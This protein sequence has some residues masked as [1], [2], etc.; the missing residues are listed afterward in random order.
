MSTSVST[1]GGLSQG[2]GD[3]IWRTLSRTLSSQSNLERD[4]RSRDSYDDLDYVERP[5]ASK[6]E[7]WA[8]MPEIKER[9]DHDEKDQFKNRKLGVT[10]TDLTVTGISADAAIAEDVISQ[11]NKPRLIAESRHAPLEK[12]ILDN[13]HGCVRPGEMLLVL[14][15]PGSGCSS[16]LKILANRR[17]GYAGVKGDV[18]FGSMNHKQAQQYRGQI[19]MNTEDEL[20]FP[21][22]TVGQT[23]DFATRMKIPMHRPSDSASAKDY[24][25]KSKDFLLRSLGISHTH[26]TKVGNEYVR[27]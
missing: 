12:T 27:G 4:P 3:V 9:R 16:L 13:V 18:N 23:L 2:Q 5:I 10:F 8:L 7:D 14:G 24:Q 11:L 19:V 26:D 25:Q 6:A 20:F 1:T 22:L 17:N 21:T 15:R